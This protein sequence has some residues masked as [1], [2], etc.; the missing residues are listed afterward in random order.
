MNKADKQ[1]TI[2]KAEDRMLSHRS[3]ERGI[4]YSEN[5]LAGFTRSAPTDLS[6]RLH[7]FCYSSP[8]VVFSTHPQIV[9]S[10]SDN[11]QRI[12]DDLKVNLTVSL[13]RK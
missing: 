11:L 6:H 5:D 13:R 10:Y 9:I 3:H 4:T 1:G 2:H 8:T 12:T 7:L